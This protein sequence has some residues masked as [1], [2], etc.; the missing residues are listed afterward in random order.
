MRFIFAPVI[1]GDYVI[2]ELYPPRVHSLTFLPLV[3]AV[4]DCHLYAP[5]S[6]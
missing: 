3:S 6:I 5:N 4:L 1:W 2:D